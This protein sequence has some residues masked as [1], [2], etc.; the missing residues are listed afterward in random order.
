MGIDETSSHLT[1]LQEAQQ[2]ISYGGRAPWF[3]GSGS[4]LRAKLTF[5]SRLTQTS[6]YSSS[7]GRG[8]MHRSIQQNPPNLI[9]HFVL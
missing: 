5:M 3:F 7:G 6:H 4:H 2:V 8:K 9:L 1:P